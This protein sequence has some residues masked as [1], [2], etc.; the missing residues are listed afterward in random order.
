LHHLAFTVLT[1]VDSVRVGKATAWTL[2]ESS[3]RG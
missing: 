2:H 1:S 3:R